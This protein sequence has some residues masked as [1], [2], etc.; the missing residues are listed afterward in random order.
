MLTLKSDTERTDKDNR[1]AKPGCYTK[2]SFNAS[3][4]KLPWRQTGMPSSRGLRTMGAHM[5]AHTAS[6]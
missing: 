3:G 6:Q 5:S 2:T 4:V 1:R